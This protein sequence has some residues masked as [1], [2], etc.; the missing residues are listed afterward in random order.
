MPFLNIRPTVFRTKDKDENISTRHGVPAVTENGFS[1]LDKEDYVERVTEIDYL[2]D[3][4]KELRKWEEQMASLP[5][6][7]RD[8]KGP[9]SALPSLKR[10][11][12]SLKAEL[13]KT[14]RDIRILQL[15]ASEY[16]Q[17]EVVLKNARLQLVDMPSIE[18]VRECTQTIASKVIWTRRRVNRSAEVLQSTGA[19]LKGACL[20]CENFRIKV[21]MQH[22]QLNKLDKTRFDGDEQLD[23]SEGEQLG[24]GI[25][26]L[27]QRASLIKPKPCNTHNF[28][29][30][31][32]KRTTLRDPNSSTLWWRRLQLLR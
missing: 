18:T 14:K 25:S 5:N 28:E 29:S 20:A 32:S 11:V 19:G 10:G 23:V 12:F 17:L 15:D 1:Y 13:K 21:I 4:I 3:M 31:Q 7:P 30:P 16:E 26:E 27:S 22:R 8:R 2:E 24:D 6:L 9:G